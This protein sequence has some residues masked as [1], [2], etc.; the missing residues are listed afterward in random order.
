MLIGVPKEVHREERRVAVTPDSAERL[1]KLGYSVVVESG[2]GA[3]A[4]FMDDEYREAGAEIV[5]EARDL[6]RRSDIVLKVRGPEPHPVLG[7]HESEL[8]KEA[9][10][11]ISFIWP[12][13]ND[14]LMERLRARR[15]T[16][17]AMDAIPRI[18]RAQKCD[19]LSSVANIAGYRAVVE[20]TN[21]FG[22]F[23]GG[24]TTAAGNVPPAKVLV[25]GAGVAGLSAVGAAVRQGAIVRAFDT[26]PAVRQQVESLGAEF[27]ELTFEEDGTGE[28]GYAKVMSPEFIKAEMDLFAHQAMEVDVIITTALIPG[29]SAP[30]LI[31][32]GM[33]ESMQG[34]SVII[35]LAAEQGGNCELTTPGEIT[36]QHGVSI[37]G[38]TDLPSRMATQSSQLYANNLWHLM[39]ELTPEK[40]GRPVVNM[41]DDLIRGATVLNGG[42]V[43]WPP[44]TL[45]PPAPPPKPPAEVTGDAPP[46]K[47]LH[48]GVK[49]AITMLIGGSLLYGIGLYAPASFMVHFTIFVLSC[50][51][52]WQVIWNVSP[53]LHTPLM[54]VTNAISGIVIVGPLLMVSNSSTLITVLAAAAVVLATI[55]IAGGFVVTQRML[56]MFRRS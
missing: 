29:K 56:Q 34:G 2:A 11:L 39:D 12:A 30:K 9:G 21:H 13:Q 37:V 50:F 10:H 18:S 55:N 31:T 19:A 33:V 42:D 27:L 54:S 52:G 15:A 44:P 46:E 35:D 25:I 32:A 48:D 17:L 38:F 53:A 43:T 22:R 5:D 16:V 7:L 3:A 8:L 45:A 23:F 4:Q 20:A 14:D 6:W 49:S 24:Q 1:Q 26:R 41:D 47:G 36:V 28:G 40:D 51:V